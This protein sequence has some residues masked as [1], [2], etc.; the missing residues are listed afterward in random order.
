MTDQT[1]T[2]ADTLAATLREL[3]DDAETQAHGF[4][5]AL[6]DIDDDPTED[7]VGLN[8]KL[9]TAMHA[10][11][12]ARLH[13]DKLAEKLDELAQAASDIAA[14]CEGAHE[15]REAASDVAGMVLDVERG[16]RDRIELL[17]ACRGFATMYVL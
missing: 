14:E 5:N 9:Q 13:A 3:G 1:M 11:E 17:E 12:D 8:E 16:V 6:I 4:G 15:E 2:N 7:A 10:L